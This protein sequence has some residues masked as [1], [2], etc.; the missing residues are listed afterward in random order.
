MTK[1]II[2]LAVVMLVALG[3]PS[4]CS[5][6]PARQAFPHATFKQVVLN[7]PPLEA[8]GQLCVAAGDLMPLFGGSASWDKHKAIVRGA[9][10]A[11][12]STGSPEA[13]LGGKPYLL[14]TAPFLLGNNFYIPLKLALAVVGQAAMDNSGADNFPLPPMQAGTGLHFRYY[15]VYDLRASYDPASGRLEGELLLAYQNPHLFPLKQLHFNLPANAAYGNGS[16]LAV[17][18]V[19]VN[20]RPV[21]A[22]SRGSRMVVPLPQQLAPRETVVLAISFCTQVAEGQTRLGRSGDVSVLAGW[23]P[24]LAPY[25]EEGWSGVAAV[26]YGEPYYTSAAHY[27]VELALPGEFQV[28]ASSRLTGRYQNGDLTVWRF[29]SEH[30]IRE[31]TFTASTS[32]QLS[33]HQLGP[34]QLLLAC[35]DEPRDII[36]DTASQALNLFQEIY[37]PYPYSFLNIAF[38]PLENFAGMEYPGLILI[39]D[40]RPFSPSV[41]VHE[42]AHQWWYNLVGSDSTREAWIDEG[43]A[44]YS[45]LLYYRNYDPALY[46]DRLAEIKRLAEQ[47]ALPVNLPLEEYGSEVA[48]RRAVYNRGALLWLQ[49]EAAAGRDRLHQALAYVQRYYRYEIVPPRSLLTAITY[50]GRIES[51]AFPHFFRN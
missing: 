40:S 5:L 10:A 13:R 28:L 3:A 15:P 26:S 49:L 46:R 2:L 45:T 19:I 30:P 33:S 29:S 41:I 43:L 50:Y 34:V 12:V 9:E 32:W 7:P 21:K 24:V 42:M 11:V 17:K 18:Q 23:Y 47:T 36:I 38:V 14:E 4:E 16:N 20:N 6:A 35:R 51:D 27:R 37:G 48:Y 1:K 31:F 22:S 44:E 39:S 25:S 8:G